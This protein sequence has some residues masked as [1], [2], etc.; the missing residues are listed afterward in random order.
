[1]HPG[2]LS[3]AV[4]LDSRPTLSGALNLSTVPVVFVNQRRHD[5]PITEWSLLHWLCALAHP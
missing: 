3:I 5:G 1:M 2:L 4:M